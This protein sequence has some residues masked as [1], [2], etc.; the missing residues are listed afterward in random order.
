M[1]MVN[2]KKERIRGKSV[3]PDALT[4]CWAIPFRNE[5]GGVGQVALPAVSLRRARA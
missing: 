2:A 1:K 3:D 4:D 5:A